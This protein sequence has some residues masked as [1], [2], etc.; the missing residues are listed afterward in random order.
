[1]DEKDKVYE[2]KLVRGFS[3]TSRLIRERCDQQSSVKTPLS[4]TILT[5][6]MIVFLGLMSLLAV[7]SAWQDIA[8]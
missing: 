2:L 5:W 4:L 7:M 8:L 3:P 6:A 1:M